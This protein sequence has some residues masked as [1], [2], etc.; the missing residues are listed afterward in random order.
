MPRKV[1]NDIA[2]GVL[3][4]LLFLI[5]I[6]AFSRFGSREHLTAAET[7]EVA[8][9][10]KEIEYLTKLGLNPGNNE[11]AKKA[12]ARLRQLQGT[13]ID[14]RTAEIDSLKK[15]IEYL[16]KLG[17]NPGNNEA[18]KKADARLKQLQTSSAPTPIPAAPTPTP[19]A[20][21]P[22]PAAPTPTPA[23][24]KP[25]PA[26]PTP[27]A[28]TFGSPIMPSAPT[29]SGSQTSEIDNLKKELAELAKFGLN[30]TN[31][32]AAKKFDTRLR[33]LQGTSAPTFSG[34]QTSE[35]ATLQKELA[36]LSKFGLNASNNEAARRFDTQLKQLQGTSTPTPAPRPV[37]SVPTPISTAFG[38]PVIPP[39]PVM[40]PALTSPTVSSSANTTAELAL[41]KTREFVEYLK[42]IGAV[43]F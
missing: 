32:E 18:A 27:M 4:V 22:I 23:T 43:K 12:D 2:V 5:L 36:D 14:P 28:A 33:Q 39:T 29:P 20:P 35:M 15:E 42:I 26:A 9:L 8:N 21:T 24:A 1:T 3:G 40:P 6:V 31:N 16:T 7:A 13:T 38:A 19:A 17:L 30:A 10:K 37:P 34:P 25:A 11:A 41:I